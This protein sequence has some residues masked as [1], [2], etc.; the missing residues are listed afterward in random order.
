VATNS[1]A[2]ACSRTSAVAESVPASASAAIAAWAVPPAPS[3]TTGP[4]NGACRSRSALRIPIQSVLSANH[5]PPP[6]SST[7]SKV[8][9]APIAAASAL[10]ASAAASATR[11]SGMVQE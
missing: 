5:W 10:T 11:L 2:R 3:S 4:V 7:R 1:D 8:L 6:S 9:A